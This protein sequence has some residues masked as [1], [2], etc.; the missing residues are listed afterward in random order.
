MEVYFSGRDHHRKWVISL[1]V[2]FVILS[3]YLSLQALYQVIVLLVLNFW[4]RNILHLNHDNR[5]HAV[6]VKNTM[7][8]NAFVLCQ[9]SNWFNNFMIQCKSFIN[10]MITISISV[11]NCNILIWSIFMI[12]KILFGN[13]VKYRYST[14]S[15][16]ASQMK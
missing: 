5:A 13:V 16:L 9:V 15:M 7:I 12:W 6:E 10:F 1:C 11:V 8:F 2:A 4:G 14:S 3:V